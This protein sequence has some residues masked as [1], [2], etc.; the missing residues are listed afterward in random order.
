LR[1]QQEILVHAG[2]DMHRHWQQAASA[3][4]SRIVVV[5]FIIAIE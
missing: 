3:V 2:P 1:Q 5:F 4:E